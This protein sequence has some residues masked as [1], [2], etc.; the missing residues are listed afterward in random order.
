MTTLA[1]ARVKIRRL[2]RDEKEVL[3]DPADFDLALTRALQ[4]YSLLR[5]NPTTQEL[6]AGA[7]GL[8]LVDDVTGFDQAYVEK[9]QIEYPG[10]ATYGQP[11]YIDRSDWWL[12]RSVGG[13]AIR[14]NYPPSTTQAL[15]ITHAV[16]HVLP[17]D[18]D[19]NPDPDGSLTVIASDVDAVCTEAAAN[20]DEML[21][22]YFTQTAD[23]STG[24]DFVN[25]T[26]KSR[27]YAAR[28]KMLHDAFEKFMANSL[29][30]GKGSFQVV[31]S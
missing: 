24:A 31:R 12:Y 10:T 20:A 26:T 28:A 9:M 19:E 3:I 14:F 5:P 30:M 7:D 8:V 18:V 21:S 4:T 16:P 17:L 2:V 11:N 15:R 29:G 23:Q 13:L 27:E 25:F 22:A 1:Q 6:F